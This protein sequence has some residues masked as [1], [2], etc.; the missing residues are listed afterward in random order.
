MRIESSTI[1]MDSFRTYT[2]GLQSTQTNII[3]QYDTGTEKQDIVQI[4]SMVTRLQAEETERSS[5]VFDGGKKTVETT[6]AQARYESSRLSSH[7]DKRRGFSLQRLQTDVSDTMKI[8]END[9]LSDIKEKNGVDPTELL[10]HSALEL[11][12]RLAGKK[13][14][15]SSPAPA[16]PED[17][18]YQSI[19]EKLRSGGLQSRF[20]VQPGEWSGI[21]QT[22][23]MVTTDSFKSKEHTAFFSTG[24]VV[25]SDGRTLNFNISVELSRRV[26]ETL[27]SVSQES[28]YTDP[29]VINLDTDAAELSDVTFYFDINNDG[30]EEEIHEL[31]SGSGF[32][33]LDKN[34]DGEINDGGELFG[35]R[36]GDGFAE[37]AQYDDDGNGW[38][39]ENDAVFSKLSVWVKCG[40]SSRLLSLSE[41]NVGAI[42]LGSQS[43][44]FGLTDSAGNTGAQLRRS[45]VFLKE[46]GEVETI[47]HV[48]FKI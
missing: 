27:V 36:T 7:E 34:G 28:I 48:D 39:D 38:I 25:T 4:D 29:L 17:A 37:L 47:Q 15:R 22:E 21:Y 20:G 3:R 8:P 1:A 35:A 19:M 24:T 42:F 44:Q 9:W 5:T 43:T 33:A 26:E 14:G 13:S 30:L 32:L 31:G 46:S 45:G 12:D 41:A 23:Q 16:S 40:D 18:Q 2:A 11:L 10:L 6:A